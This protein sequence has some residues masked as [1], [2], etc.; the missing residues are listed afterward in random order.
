VSIAILEPDPLKDIADLRRAVRELQQGR[1]GIIFDPNGGRTFPGGITIGETF[2]WDPVPPP[3]D[4]LL[5]WGSDFDRIF[6]DA[7]WSPPG[8]DNA[9]QVATYLAELTETGVGVVQ[10]QGGLGGNSF[11]FTG[12]KPNTEYSVRVWS[13]NRLGRPSTPLGPELI[14]TGTDSTAP[15]A[16]TGFAL[17]TGIGAILATWAENPEEDVRLGRGM[18]EVEISQSPLLGSDGRFAVVEDSKRTA[19]LVQDFSGLTPTPPRYVHVRAIDSSG[20]FG[21]FSATLWT[22]PNQVQ[23]PDLANFAVTTAKIADL[24]VNNAKI[25]NVAA[26]KLTSDSITTAILTIEG[27]GMLRMGRT[28]APFNYLIEDASGLR[29]YS[30]GSAPFTGG[31]LVMDLN[32]QTGNAF[33]GGSLS[34]GVSITSPVITGGAITGTVFQTATSGPR[35]ALTTTGPDAHQVAVYG[36]STLTEAGYLYTVQDGTGTA[37][38]GRT[39]LQSAGAGGGYAAFL[40]LSSNSNSG[41]ILSSAVLEAQRAVMS[42]Y[43]G[44]SIAVASDVTIVANA[45]G[46][47]DLNDKVALSMAGFQQVLVDGGVPGQIGT[48][49]FLVNVTGLGFRRLWVGVPDSGGAGRRA[50][51]VPNT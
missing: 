2:V 40:H 24:A 8:G 18:Y 45:S 12:I 17:R 30:G 6:I 42:S 50:V 51:Y 13:Y 41:A 25:N 15:S 14:T 4:L 3:T 22:I 26:G 29:F 31:T 36:P 21:P 1:G 5:S 35:V 10:A 7:T 19:A 23:E 37:R 20:N 28:S 48:I 47:I 9:D 16:P 39:T 11:R 32:I 43:G 46:R 33:F 34:A 44:G 38:Q 49:S 27:A